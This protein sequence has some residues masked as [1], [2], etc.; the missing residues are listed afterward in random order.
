M[1]SRRLAYL[2]MGFIAAVMLTIIGIYVAL[3][4]VAVHFIHKLW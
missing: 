2:I 3:G 1:K 4:A